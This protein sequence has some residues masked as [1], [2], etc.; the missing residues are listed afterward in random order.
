MSKLCIGANIFVRHAAMINALG[1]LLEKAY[2]RRSRDRVLGT[3][4]TP[5][6]VVEI[7]SHN[8]WIKHIH[9]NEKLVRRLDALRAGQK[10]MLVVGGFTGEWEKMRNGS[11]GSLPTLGVK[12]I[13]KAR[14]HWHGL[15]AKRGKKVE[16]R[17]AGEKPKPV[18]ASPTRDV[19][20]QSVRSKSIAPELLPENAIKRAKKKGS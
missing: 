7:R 1:C 10:I 13:G 2:K 12:P 18:A 4:I 15:Q 17:E 3:E 14:K 16:I 9:G 6:S 8:I 11:G 20:R 19:V 5:M